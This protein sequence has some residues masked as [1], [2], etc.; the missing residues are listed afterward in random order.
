M[1][2]GKVA[3]ATVSATEIDKYLDMGVRCLRVPQWRSW[4]AAG[5]RAYVGQVHEHAAAGR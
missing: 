4:I 5:A 1:A 2:A 3:G